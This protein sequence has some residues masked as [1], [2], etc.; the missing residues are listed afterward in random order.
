MKKGFFELEKVQVKQVS[1]A[2]IGMLA[3][4]LCYTLKNVIFVRHLNYIKSW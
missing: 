3:V 1:T 4:M 2:Y